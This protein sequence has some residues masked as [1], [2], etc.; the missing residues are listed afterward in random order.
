MVVQIQLMVVQQVQPMETPMYLVQVMEVVHQ[1]LQEVHGTIRLLQDMVVVLPMVML[2]GVLLELLVLVGVPLFQ[3]P[4][5]NLQVEL[6]DTGI[7]VMVMVVDMAEMMGLMG[8]HLGM[9]L[10]E[11]VSGVVQIAIPQQVVVVLGEIYRLGVTWEVVMAMLME[12]QGMEIQD[13]GLTP[14]K[15]LGTMVVKVMGLKRDMVAMAVLRP[16]RLSSSDFDVL[17]LRTDKSM[18]SILGA[19]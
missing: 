9:V 12:I 11:A 16:D 1:V 7:K 15:L 8:I 2:L 18:P 4:Q 3:H 13:G 5:V 10:L 6:L 14:H 19:K 17:I